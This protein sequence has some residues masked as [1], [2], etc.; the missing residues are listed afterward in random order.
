MR[1]FSIIFLL[2]ALRFAAAAPTPAPFD[3]GDINLN[4]SGETA[5][6]DLVE[7]PQEDIT[8]ELV[9]P[10]QFT[11]A[12]YCSSPVVQ[13][14]SCGGPCDALGN[15]KIL[16]AGGDDALIPNFFVA[17][18]VDA[19]TIVVAHQG[20]NPKNLLS[21]LNDLNFLQVDPDRKILPAAGGK[22]RAASRVG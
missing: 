13:N 11:R 20:T 4:F 22:W 5:D 8:S 14:L 2:A 10:A 12:A 1:S 16:A 6:E 7:V 17:H 21:D 18:D 9:R 3:L 15:V 19:N